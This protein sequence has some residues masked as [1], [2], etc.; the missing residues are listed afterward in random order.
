M[1]E[2]RWEGR[3]LKLTEVRKT[4]GQASFIYSYLRGK[5]GTK[6]IIYNSFASMP[7]GICASK[8]NLPSELLFF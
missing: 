1:N 7:L 6:F 4:R 3:L 5:T 2:I 8:F